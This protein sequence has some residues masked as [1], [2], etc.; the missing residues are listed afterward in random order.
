M[1]LFRP[2]CWNWPFDSNATVTLKLHQRRYQNENRKLDYK[3]ILHQYKPQAWID[4]SVTEHKQCYKL[5]IKSH[6]RRWT[7]ISP[8]S[9]IPARYYRVRTNKSHEEISIFFFGRRKIY[10]KLLSVCAVLFR[11]QGAYDSLIHIPSRVFRHFVE[12]LQNPWFKCQKKRIQK[13]WQAIFSNYTCT[14]YKALKYFA[15]VDC[16]Y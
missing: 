6:I 15:V 10:M 2:L 12:T 5:T 11:N 4:R 13:L 3:S 7:G 14:S 16:L 8:V 9:F 1:F